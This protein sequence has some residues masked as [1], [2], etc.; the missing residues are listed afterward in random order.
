VAIR[1]YGEYPEEID[2]WI[3]ANDAEAERLAAALARESELLG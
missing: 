3:A 2:E 1:Y